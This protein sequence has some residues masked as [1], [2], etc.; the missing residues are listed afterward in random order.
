MNMFLNKSTFD[1]PTKEHFVEK[2]KDGKHLVQG[3]MNMV[4]GAEETSL[5]QIFFPVWFLLNVALYTHWEAQP[6]FY[7]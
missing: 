5:N 2:E 6:F 7:W 3:L 4:D 1:K